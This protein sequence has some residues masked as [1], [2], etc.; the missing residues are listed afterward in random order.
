MRRRAGAARALRTRLFHLVYILQKLR[1]RLRLLFLRTDQ[2]TLP[3][4]SFF[5]DSRILQD[6]T[7]F[8]VAFRLRRWRI[9]VHLRNNAYIFKKDLPGCCLGLN[10]CFSIHTGEITETQCILNFK[11]RAWV[12]ILAASFRELI[13]LDLQKSP[14][15]LQITLLQRVQSV[16]IRLPNERL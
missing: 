8:I 15:I 11:R 5:S 4:L 12:F 10:H 9:R 16:I 6:F 2:L 14:N 13:N 1:H 7:S 3:P